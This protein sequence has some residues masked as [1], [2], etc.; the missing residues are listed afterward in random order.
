MARVVRP[1]GVIGFT[2]WTRE[3]F[4][5]D[6]VELEERFLTGGIEGSSPPL[7]GTE[8]T[9]RAAVEPLAAHVEINRETLSITW[10]SVDAFTDAL[11]AQDPYLRDLRRQLPP[12]RWGAFT[13]EL[14]SL[15]HKWNSHATGGLRLE[16]P[17]LRV[18]VNTLGGH[19]E[20][21]D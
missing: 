15:V 6:W 16:F 5:R 9:A 4:N 11:I 20:T 13:D 3:G 1:G 8:P 7:L 14:R 18:V 2:R 19:E 10:S 12:T 21:F 17:Y